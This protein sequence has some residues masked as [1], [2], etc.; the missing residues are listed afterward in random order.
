MYKSFI[1]F[2]LL[3]LVINLNTNAQSSLPENF[4]YGHIENNKYINKYFDYEMTF[5][6]KWHVQNQNQMKE[7]QK[8]GNEIFNDGTENSKAFIKAAEVNT[9]NLIGVFKYEL[10]TN[11]SQFNPCILVIAENVKLYNG[12]RSGKDYLQAAMEMFKMQKNVTYQYMDT[13]YETVKIDT[14]QFYKMKTIIAI[15][16]LEI[17]QEYYSIVM[18]GF[19]FNFIISFISDEQKEELLK[20]VNS[21]NFNYSKTGKNNDNIII[22]PELEELAFKSLVEDNDYEKAIYYYSKLAKTDNDTLLYAAKQY[23]RI[24]DIYGINL[25]DSVSEKSANEK[26]ISLINSSIKKYPLYLNSYLEKLNCYKFGLIKEN[27]QSFI[28]EINTK[29]SSNNWLANYKLALYNIH[30]DY[31]TSFDDNYK[32]VSDFLLKSNELNPSHFNTILLL[33][34][35]LPNKNNDTNNYLSKLYTLNPGYFKKNTNENRKKYPYIIET[36]NDGFTPKDFTVNLSI[37]ECRSL[38]LIK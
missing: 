23:G 10:G 2:T 38:K 9:A 30:G 35:S 16:G 19:A 22:R 11:M 20:I 31:L 34:V 29:F 3:F 18:K 6:L 5:P 25:N 8:N 21:M 27:P 17:K 33:Y 24:A 4:D 36:K 13:I 1:N 14:K 32:L 12:I 15:R 26:Y 28:D 7:L 37:D